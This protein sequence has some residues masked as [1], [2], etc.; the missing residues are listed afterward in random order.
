MLYYEVEGIGPVREDV[1]IG[2]NKPRTICPLI[3]QV[4]ANHQRSVQVVADAL[5]VS[6]RTVR[7]WRGEGAD[8]DVKVATAIVAARA[9]AK[10]EVKLL[11]AWLQA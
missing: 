7:A 10:R 9:T 3:V 1:A 6:D 11:V 5:R 2:L 8:A 4:L